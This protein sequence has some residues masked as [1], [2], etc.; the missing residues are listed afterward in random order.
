MDITTT[1][2]AAL[3]LAENGIAWADMQLYISVM[4]GLVIVMTIADLLHK[5]SA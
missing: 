3:Q 1:P 2:I 5:K 4:I